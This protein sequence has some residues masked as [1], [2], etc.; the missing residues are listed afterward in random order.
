MDL[1]LSDE[2][3][4]KTD[5]TDLRKNSFTD[6]TDKQPMR[7]NCL[8]IKEINV[9][10]IESTCNKVDINLSSSNNLDIVDE[11]FKSYFYN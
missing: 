4:M 9:S 1:M 5:V 7:K 3:E 8:T 10:P 2:G 11:D 6:T